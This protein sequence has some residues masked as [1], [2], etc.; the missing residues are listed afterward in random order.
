M[1]GTEREEKLDID[2]LGETGSKFCSVLELF[3][4]LFPQLVQTHENMVCNFLFL[5][6]MTF[7]SSSSPPLPL[8]YSFLPLSFFSPS[9]LLF[10]RTFSP[11]FLAYYSPTQKISLD[12]HFK[13]IDRIE[14]CFFSSVQTIKNCLSLSLLL[15]FYISFSF[16]LPVSAIIIITIIIGSQFTAIHLIPKLRERGRKS[17]LDRKMRIG[18]K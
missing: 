17:F 1:F 2:F 6:T 11:I 9:L 7:L 14:K 12:L 4:V 13:K 10:F 3:P 16:F 15:P 5:Q 8:P 18:S